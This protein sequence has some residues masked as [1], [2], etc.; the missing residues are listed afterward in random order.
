MK[1]IFQ[2]KA[3]LYCL[4]KSTWYIGVGSLGNV[5]GNYFGDYLKFLNRSSD[6]I[7][8]MKDWDA[9]LKDIHYGVQ[10]YKNINSK[11]LLTYETPRIL[12]KGR[13][14]NSRR[15]LQ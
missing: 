14:G 3:E 2:Y 1:S 4:P 12:N 7:M 5:S 6:F 11:S 13:R 8:I 9:V 15:K 10:T